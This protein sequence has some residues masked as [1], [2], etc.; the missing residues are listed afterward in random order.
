[1]LPL[2]LPAVALALPLSPAPVAAPAL[3]EPLLPVE[4][5]APLEPCPDAAPADEL[6]VAPLPLF[7]LVVPEA[8]VSLLPLLE[9]P[10][11]T[12]PLVAIIESPLP[13]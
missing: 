4:V 11:S 1:M 5:I 13:D 12:E 3:P 2:L 10:L 7:E 6:P 8:A 9:L